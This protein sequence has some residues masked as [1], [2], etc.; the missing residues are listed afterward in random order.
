MSSQNFIKPEVQLFFAKLSNDRRQV[1]CA[2]VADTGL[3]G[4]SRQRRDLDRAAGQAFD[5]KSEQQLH[6]FKRYAR[7]GGTGSF[8][9]TAR[10]ERVLAATGAWIAGKQTRGRP[11]CALFAGTR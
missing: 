5:I 11:V 9:A 10:L 8:V 4:Y 1:N 2:P 7:V 6:R 3:N